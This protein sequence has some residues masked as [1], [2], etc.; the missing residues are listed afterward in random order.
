VRDGMSADDAVRAWARER[1]AA[2][3]SEPLLALLRLSDE[4]IKEGLYIDELARRKLFFRRLRLPP[5]LHVFWDHIVISHAMCK[6][7]R[8]YVRDPVG[9]LTQSWAALDKIRSMRAL[10]AELGLPAE[11]F[12]FQYDTFRMLAAAREY[13]FGSFGPHRV[14]RLYAL[15]AEYE[16]KYAVRY[17]VRL[18]FCR[19]R[20]S[21]YHLRLGFALLFRSQRGYRWVDRLLLIR[22]LSW[23]SPLLA[24]R[25][26]RDDASRLTDQAMGL[27]AVL[28]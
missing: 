4:T 8:C 6:L 14:E 13:Y 24:L 15:R 23:L 11:D 28:K 1:L 16:H 9:K 2:G 5:L 7:L 19:F 20:L 12:D 10:A 27:R 21:R 3:K 25:R 17:H 22:L 18:D 26:R